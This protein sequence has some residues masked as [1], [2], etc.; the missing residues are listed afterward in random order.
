MHYL[1]SESKGAEQIRSN[2]EADL[3]LVFAY[4]KCLFSHDVAHMLSVSITS[5]VIK[6]RWIRLLLLE[7]GNHVVPRGNL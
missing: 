2:C 3:H 6:A 1:C 4:A 5:S 7:K